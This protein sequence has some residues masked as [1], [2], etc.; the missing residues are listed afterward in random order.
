MPPCNM[1]ENRV[2]AQ[3]HFETVSTYTATLKISIKSERSG[4]L[5]TVG[6]LKYQEL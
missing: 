5:R 6:M 4:L 2:V 1:E 3:T